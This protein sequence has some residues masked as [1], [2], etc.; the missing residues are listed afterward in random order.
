LISASQSKPSLEEL[1]ILRE[2]VSSRT[3]VLEDPFVNLRR[4]RK[5]IPEGIIG[6]HRIINIENLEPNAGSG[7]VF[8]DDDTC[9]GR[10]RAK[11]CSIR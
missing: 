2:C 11:L 4:L 6:C 10:M 9:I 8:P 1:E 7:I 3:I 5:R